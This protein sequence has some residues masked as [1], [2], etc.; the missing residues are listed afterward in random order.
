[1]D[2][3]GGLVLVGDDDQGVDLE[4]GELA[5]DVDGV[6]AGDEVDEDV[7]QPLGYLAEQ[8]GR[9]LLVAGVLLE[10]DGDEQLLSFGV[11][12]THVHA[13]FMRKQYPV[14]LPL[15]ASLSLFLFLYIS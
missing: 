13:S 12:V 2:G 5:V 14:A 15:L 9:D 4:V 3:G 6:E 8:A 1:M 10:V 7:V 11:D